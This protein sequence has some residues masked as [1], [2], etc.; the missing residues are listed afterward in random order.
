MGKTGELTW[1][2]MSE[3]EFGDIGARAA[4]KRCSRCGLVKPTSQFGRDSARRDG[5]TPWCKDCQARYRQERKA[6]GA[7][8]TCSIEGCDAR[9]QLGIA[10]QQHVYR[11]QGGTY[12]PSCLECAERTLALV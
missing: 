10:P 6:A 2:E 1:V 8:A 5:L 4:V 7:V 3:E 12:M 9:Q 11:C